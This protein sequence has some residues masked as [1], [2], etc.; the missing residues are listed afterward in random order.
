MHLNTGVKQF[1]KFGI[2]GSLGT[3]TNL[4]IFF[5]CADLLNLPE[6]P[7]S[8]G[9]FLIAGMQN[10]IINHKWTFSLVMSKS[11]LT[12]KKYFLFL[13]GS[14]AGL[15]VNIT[16]MTSIIMNV[17]LPYKFIAQACGIVAG[18]LINFGISKTLVFRRKNCVQ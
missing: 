17:N 3:V 4:L 2:T 16:V 7:I 12:V 14:L 6:I 1:I 18:M 8:I 9:C 13:S 5:L 11:A 15:L 10:Y